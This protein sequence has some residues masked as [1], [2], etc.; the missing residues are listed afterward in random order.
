MELGFKNLNTKLSYMND[1]IYKSEK[2]TNDK[3]NPIEINEMYIELS[4]YQI[5]NSQLKKKIKLYQQE[6]D[7]N[8]CEWK[9]KDNIIFEYETIKNELEIKLNEIINHNSKDW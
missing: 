6:E 2:I 5:E 3:E 1:N 4:N 8:K 7:N 9:K